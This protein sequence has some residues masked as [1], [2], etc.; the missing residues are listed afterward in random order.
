MSTHPSAIDAQVGY[1]LPPFARRP[2]FDHWNR[3]AAVNEEFVP[4]HMDDA[5]AREA[6]YPRA[7]GMGR[8]LWSYLHCMLRD[9][10]DDDGRIVSVA[11]QFRGPQLRGDQAIA[12][13]RVT[14]V[15]D[16]SG[17]RIVDLEVWI[18]SGDGTVLAP[19]TATVAIRTA[20]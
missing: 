2:G 4:I 1:E 13:G 5:A 12:R 3:F 20:R 9:W 17:E 11:A 16:L 15:R 7:I 8:L 10:L 19:G 14:A 18:E 6:G